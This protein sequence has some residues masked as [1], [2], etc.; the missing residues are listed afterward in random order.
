MSRSPAGVVA[1]TRDGDSK[2]AQPRLSVLELAKEFGRGA[3]NAR[4]AQ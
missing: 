2:V 1:R 4:R 3:S